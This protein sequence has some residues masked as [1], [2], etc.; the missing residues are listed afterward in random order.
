MRALALLAAGAA[1]SALAFPPAARAADAIAGKAAAEPCAACHGASG[2][3]PADEIPSLAGQPA[4][5][6]EWQLVFFRSGTRKNE[7][8]Q[9]IAAALSNV[10]IRDLAA[11]FS[12]LPPPAPVPDD[13]PSLSS[14]GAKLA[15][16][17]RCASCHK[18][19]FAGENAAPR[20]ADQ[21]ESYLLKALRDF[22]SGAR[23]GG[24]VASMPET[25]YPL[26]DDDLK[27]LAHYLARLPRS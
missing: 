14:A 25:V 11:Y 27:A 22:K 7:V 26:A 20:L 13:Q 21:H 23:T 1:F 18:E 3:S 5:Y 9:P 12:S 6:I 8:M 2:I 4:S 24:G 19:K 16:Q 17:H 15:L 10:A